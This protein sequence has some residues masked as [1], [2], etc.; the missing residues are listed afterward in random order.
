V[1]ESIINLDV[2]TYAG[3]P[4][5]L[6]TLK[7]DSRYIF[8]KGDIGDSALVAELLR[9]HRPRAIINFAA[10]SHVDRSIHGPEDFIQTNIVGTFC[11]LEAARDYWGQLPQE[12]QKKFR[13]LHVSTDE[14]YGTLGIQDPAFKETNQ[15]APT[16][17]IQ[18]AK[19]PATTWSARTFTPTVCQC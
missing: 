2:L 4:D 1:D 12:Q 3:N 15:Y 16:V 8:I 18:R 9:T 17:P 7:G 6:K 10:E 14:V 13:F 5:N 19:R 11:L